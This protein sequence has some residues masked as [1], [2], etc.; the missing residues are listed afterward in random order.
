M[1]LAVEITSRLPTALCT[2]QRTISNLAA[3]AAHL[4]EAL[5]ILT[6]GA[7]DG[8]AIALINDEGREAPILYT[9]GEWKA[10]DAAAKAAR[11]WKAW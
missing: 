11:N 5:R 10:A 3:V 6:P 4:G 7:Q 2:D 1:A 8:D 9:F